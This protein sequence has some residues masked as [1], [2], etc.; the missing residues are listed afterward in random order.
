LNLC[1]FRDDD[2]I[3]GT[4]GT[5]KWLWDIGFP[6]IP[7]EYWKVW[8]IDGQIVGYITQFEIPFSKEPRL[9]FSTIYFASY[10]VPT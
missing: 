5:Q 10:E 8:K 3:C 4:I 2:I 7:E 9:T 6:I 1:I